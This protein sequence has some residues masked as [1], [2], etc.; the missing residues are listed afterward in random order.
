MT[1]WRYGE[2]ECSSC[3][4]HEL[5]REMGMIVPRGEVVAIVP[6]SLAPQIDGRMLVMSYKIY[7]RKLIRVK[8]ERITEL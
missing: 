1:V 3:T 4:L 8:A 6:C 5:D 7:W 2:L